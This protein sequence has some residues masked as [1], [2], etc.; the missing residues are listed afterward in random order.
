MTA[1]ATTSRR[2]FVCASSDAYKCIVRSN[3][4]IYLD[5]VDGN[6]KC[7]NGP[8]TEITSSTVRLIALSDE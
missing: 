7:D 4:F 3:Y 8:E 6:G 2:H 5:S 1:E